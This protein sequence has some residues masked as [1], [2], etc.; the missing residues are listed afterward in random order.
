MKYTHIKKILLALLCT[1]FIHTQETKES[2][3][4][5]LKHYRKATHSIDAA[6]QKRKFWIPSLY[7]SPYTFFCNSAKKRL[8]EI[9]HNLR[10][11]EKNAIKAF[12]QEHNISD[13]SLRKC[14]SI[15][16]NHKTA[17]QDFLASE[18]SRWNCLAIHD[19]A[20]PQEIIRLLKQNGINPQK[21][22]LINSTQPYSFSE[23]TA[24]SAQSTN[25]RLEISDKIVIT[26][27]PNITVYPRFHE[28]DTLFHK[29]TLLHEMEH[30]LS[31]HGITKVWLLRYAA[32]NTNKSDDDIRQSA[33]YQELTTIH[34]R[35]AE[36]FSALKNP[37]YSYAHRNDRLHDYYEGRTFIKHYSQLAEIDELHKLQYKLEH[38]TPMPVQKIDDLR[39]LKRSIDYSFAT[40]AIIASASMPSYFNNSSGFPERGNFIA[41]SE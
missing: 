36:I 40:S 5:T 28:S 29:S 37:E 22:S 6:L 16:T 34:E 30:I 11:E 12:A 18:P 9:E 13:K 1:P 19:S 33:T 26:Q 3:P 39:T 14:L 8:A 7:M 20:F 23:N 31:G 32:Q 35:Q 41:A 15:I 25:A 4:E 2:S 24:A 38:Y 21:I 27:P 10:V 17:Q